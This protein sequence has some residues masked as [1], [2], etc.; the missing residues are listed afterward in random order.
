MASLVAS[1]VISGYEMRHHCLSI[2]ATDDP[3][4]RQFTLMHIQ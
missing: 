4:G 3:E 2:G 1:F